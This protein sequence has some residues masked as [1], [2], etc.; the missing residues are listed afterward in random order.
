[1]AIIYTYTLVTP[2]PLDSVVI[3]DASDN[4]YTKTSYIGDAVAASIAP[5]A[6]IYFTFG[7]GI[8]TINAAD[9]DLG[10]TWINDLE[11]N[12]ELTENDNGVITVTKVDV[13]LEAGASAS[14]S[15]GDP[16][17]VSTPGAN[18]ML[19]ASR[20]YAGG[21]NIGHVPAGGGA[22][23]Y[24]DGGT[25]L[26]TTLP[27]DQN[28]TY[29]LDSIQNAS[30]SD[31]RLVGSDGT[32]DIVKLVAG[33]NITLTDTGSNITI[34]AAS[35]AY[36]WII[37]DTVGPTSYTVGNTEQVIFTGTGGITVTATDAGGGS[38]PYTI[39]ID[40]SGGTVTEVD[41]VT[42]A[43]VSPSGLTLGTDP[44][45]GITTTGDVTL[46]WNGSIGDLLYGADDG[47]GNAVLTALPIGPSGSVLTSDGG[48][49]PGWTAPTGGCAESIGT[50]ETDIDDDITVSGC[51]DTITF[52]SSD[53]SIEITGANATSTIDFE[54][55]CASSSAKGGVLVSSTVPAV[56]P[57]L[58]TE[59][60][61]YP[62][63]VNGDCEAMVRVPNTSAPVTGEF[64]PRL[65]SMG[66]DGTGAFVQHPN[67]VHLAASRG[68]YHVVNSQ[69]YI[70][71]YVKFTLDVSLTPVTETLGVAWYDTVSASLK[72]LQDLPGLANLNQDKLHNAGVNI[73][74]AY[75]LADG[76][77]IADP[78]WT[79]SPRGGQLNRFFDNV[80]SA[81]WLYWI[82]AGA[83]GKTN[84]VTGL[85]PNAW[86]DNGDG[87]EFIIA[88]SLNPILVPAL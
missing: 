7:G 76:G 40:G 68:R 31:I 55:A 65:V 35:G 46:K 12:I 71:F 4:N 28:T 51:S 57:V 75:A 34:D 70:D 20:A 27:A 14:L 73:T 23:E 47:A 56:S 9:Y 69:V 87:V 83:N 59:G 1:M 64:E 5:G 74:Q 16:L 38:A 29:D 67:V 10:G 25:G 58:A 45:A 3:T 26:W 86:V 11:Y 24:L 60:D 63:Q 21:S 77:A 80:N 8:T 22:G 42:F 52:T 13:E 33:T 2:Q 78:G 88:G 36:S 43:S 72:G 32:T 62:L 30:D 19:L 53:G 50:I 48:V 66:A 85:L 49:I 84:Y 81:A 6:N 82:E 41:A 37:E 39:T 18:R 54:V 61:Y 44:I 79:L 17:I 15:T